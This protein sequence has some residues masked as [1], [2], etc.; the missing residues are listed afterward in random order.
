MVRFDN[1]SSGATLKAQNSSKK[2]FNINLKS[3]DPQLLNDT[4]IYKIQIIFIIKIFKRKKWFL[5]F[6]VFLA[7]FLK[8]L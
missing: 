6:L 3:S 7:I 4:N 2:K 5:Q 1:I 8:I